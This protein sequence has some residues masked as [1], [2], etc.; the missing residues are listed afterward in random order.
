MNTPT[1]SPR[2][3]IKGRNKVVTMV[4]TLKSREHAHT[5]CFSEK[6][7]NTILPLLNVLEELDFN[8]RTIVLAHLDDCS[9][10]AL[11][12]LI[13]IVIRS[14]HVQDVEQ[15]LLR[16]ELAPY[17]KN[18]GYLVNNKFKNKKKKR[19]NLVKIGGGP[20][21]TI[22]QTGIPILLRLFK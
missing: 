19:E 11:I 20:L 17:K 9:R 8:H 21:S 2:C 7:R 3:I 4:K 10:D 12:T 13:S 16:Q 6:Q 14:K 18:I 15:E 1:S 5:Y 22:L